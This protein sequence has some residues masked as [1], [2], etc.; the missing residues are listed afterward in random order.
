MIHSDIKA[1][2]LADKFTNETLTEM[3]GERFTSLD[4]VEE[5]PEIDNKWEYLNEMFY[6]AIAKVN[7]LL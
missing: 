3:Y 5:D 2:D 7:Y 4:D 1:Q 6:Q